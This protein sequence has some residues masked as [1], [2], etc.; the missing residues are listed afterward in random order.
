MKKAGCYFILFG[1]QTL[2]EKVLQNVNRKVDQAEIEKA[3][4]MTKRLGMIVRLDFILGLPG[5]TPENMR[6]SID[7]VR[8]TNPDI[9][10]FY[11]VLWLPGTELTKKYRP[12]YSDEFLEKIA[13]EF[14]KLFYFRIQ[15]LSSILKHCR[16]PAYLWRYFQCFRAL[17]IGMLAKKFPNLFGADERYQTPYQGN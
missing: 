7:F 4:T 15:S 1:V 9:V 8:E 2:D 14:Y 12:H 10:D 11:P 16:R 17:L 6:R 13:Q 5:S 3:V